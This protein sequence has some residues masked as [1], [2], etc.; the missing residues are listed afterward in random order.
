MQVQ[1]AKVN[2]RALVA[3]CLAHITHD[4]IT[5]ML[6]VFF[7]IWQNQ[8]SLSLTQI[9]LIKTLYSGSMA[10]FQ[11]PAGLVAAR[12]GEMLPLTVGTMLTGFA[13]ISFG[14]SSSF[15]ILCILMVFGGLG[16]SF[17]HPLAS[18]LVS[19]AY[20]DN[21]KRRVALSTYNMSGD[22]GKLLLP[23]L[24]ALVIAGS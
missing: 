18:S 7:P 20:P 17:Q 12:F 23:G 22:L 2:N 11:F 19:G 21:K 14:G 4:G 3:G 13:V 9:G 10:L 5:D 15:F 24:A 6:Y 1:S 8:L 16:A